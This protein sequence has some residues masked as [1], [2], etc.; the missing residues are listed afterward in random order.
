MLDPGELDPMK[1]SS[2][3][4]GELILHALN[5]GIK[6][7]LIGIGGSAT[8]DGGMGAAAALGVRFFDADGGELPGCGESMA[9]VCSMDTSGMPSKLE[10]VDIRVMCDV[11]NPMT[12]E[13]GATMVFGPQKGASGAVL[14]ELER[15]MKNLERVYND[16][17]CS[18][19]CSEPGTGAAGGMGAM[20]RVLLGAELKSGAEA[21]LEAVHFDEL[22]TEADLVITGEGC[23]DGDSVD[24]GKAVGT[25]LRHAAAR[26]V[27]AA[28]IA[29]CFGEGYERAAKLGGV[30]LKSCINRPMT[31]EY[32]MEHSEELLSLAAEELLRGVAA[33]R[34]TR[35][36]LLSR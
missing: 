31:L 19:V 29:G 36:R 30:A 24:S 4:T 5:E 6:H 9:K 8:N 21:V 34:N 17:H 11:K 28:V 18:E 16:Y 22:L 15:G 12:G 25:V 2:F 32:A 3:G 14:D 33:V 10:T 13:N 1:A 35:M 23:L 26:E 20:L 7:I 27:P